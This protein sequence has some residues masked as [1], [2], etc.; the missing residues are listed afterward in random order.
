VCA[1]ESSIDFIENKEK[2]C[3]LAK[4]IKYNFPN[5]KVGFQHARW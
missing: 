3:G 5:D 2:V 1:E 4:E